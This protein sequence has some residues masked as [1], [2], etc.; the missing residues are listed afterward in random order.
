M[1]IG[2]LTGPFGVS[3]KEVVVLEENLQNPSQSRVAIREYDPISGAIIGQEFIDMAL[4][5]GNPE[6]AAKIHLDNKA[7]RAAGI[8]LQT[9]A[10][11]PLLPLG[12][13]VAGAVGLGAR[14]KSIA[15]GIKGMFVQPKKIP[16]AGGQ[17][18]TTKGN[19]VGQQSGVM[20][21]PSK[22]EASGLVKNVAQTS[23][24]IGGYMGISA[25]QTDP[26]T[27]D[28][29]IQAEK[30]AVITQK[31]GDEISKQLKVI[32]PVTDP[33]EII[34]TP[35]AGDTADG[36]SG[37][38]TGGTGQESEDGDGEDNIKTLEQVGVDRFIDPDALISFV[39]N[40]GAG[41]TSTGQFGTG[42]A[43]GATMAA[44]ERAKKEILETQEKKEI[45]KE[46]ALLEKKFELDKKLLKMKG[47]EPTLDAKEV[48]AQ[49]TNLSDEISKFKSNEQARGLVE[50]SIMVLQD[51]IDS[52]EKLTGV[53]GF[54]NKLQDQ[55]QA[56]VSTQEGFDNLSARTKIDKL[57]EIVKLSNAREILN[58]TRL[59]N[60]ERQILGDAFGELKTLE[61]PSI[62]LGKFRKSLQTLKEN[63]EIR[64]DLISTLHEGLLSGGLLGGSS[65]ERTAPDVIAIKNIDLN[66]STAV[67]TLN[68]L[69]SG[70]EFGGN[71]IGLVE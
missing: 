48:A 44:E 63:N 38:A 9:A 32:K 64:Q 41:L 21:D 11:A 39:R 42:L 58:D 47:T 55:V 35:D 66:L 24:F 52:G 70:Q 7:K 69:I 17:R 71:V 12:G 20:I 60:Y 65:F 10:L 30:D 14:A 62:A 5:P 4:A 61:D 67:E 29:L 50:A 22:L 18:T 15:S 6:L 57:S 3:Q 40:V 26:L 45:Q 36:T 37:S 23:P 51:A 34:Q 43:V 25:L 54:F 19:V 27:G 33:N 56:L 59:S 31:Q 53:G 2:P 46:E 16:L 8:T 13:T 68:R 49:S 28:D 1:S